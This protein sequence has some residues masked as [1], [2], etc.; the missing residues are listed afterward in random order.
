MAPASTC[1]T[2]GTCVSKCSSWLTQLVMRAPR[3]TLHRLRA[4]FYIP[5]DRVLVQDLVRSCTTCQRNKTETVHPAGLL[6]PLDV[7]T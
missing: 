5:R 3:K 1:Q 6:Q 4:D 7:P 2:K